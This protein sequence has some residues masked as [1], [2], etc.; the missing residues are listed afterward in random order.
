M[1]K[2]PPSDSPHPSRLG[3]RGPQALPPPEA[4]LYEKLHLKS[5]LPEEGLEPDPLLP[6]AKG[7]R[8]TDVQAEENV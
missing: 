6:A 5:W 3:L 4:P 8:S 1:R 7:V 2:Q